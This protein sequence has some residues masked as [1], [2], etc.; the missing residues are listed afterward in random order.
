MYMKLWHPMNKRI[1]Q[2]VS[3]GSLVG[4]AVLIA[5][6][7]PMSFGTKVYADRFDDQLRTLQSQANQAQAQADQFRAQADT[8][9]NKLNQITAEKTALEAQIQ[10]SQAKKV[11]LESDIAANTKKMQDTQSALGETLANLY[12]DGKVSALEMLA[13]S[14]NIGDYIDKQSY[15]STVRDQ[16]KGSIDTI[17]KIKKQLEDDKKALEKVLSELDAQNQQLAAAQA[18]QQRLVD[19]TRGEEAAYQNLVN[20]TRSQMADISAQQRSYYQS[21]IASGKSGGGVVGSFQYTNL[22]PNNGAGG[23]S[24]GYPSKWCAA[25]DTVVDDWGLYNRECVSYVAWALESRFGKYVGNFR[26]QGNAYQWPSAASAY[27]GAYRVADPQP[28]DVVVLPQS[29]SF[30]PVGHVMIVESVSGG[31]MRVSQFNFYGTGQYSTMDVKNS[32][33]ILL[34]FK[35]R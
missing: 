29:G 7:V 12:V 20:S 3:R 4:M 19:Q 18:E 33:V 23:C 5:M 24:G 15:R 27:S 28:G 31:W 17:K 35:D 9:Q 13:S 25:Q 21:L 8:L 11:Q 6:A 1:S 30:A 32:G 10:V 26:G 34:R 14:Q 2:T 22:S 16:L